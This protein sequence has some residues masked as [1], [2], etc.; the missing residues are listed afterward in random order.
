[1]EGEGDVIKKK[2]K[3]NAIKA[4]IETLGERK[5]YIMRGRNYPFV[6]RL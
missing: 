1:M 2:I 3:K 5:D 6:R 4:S